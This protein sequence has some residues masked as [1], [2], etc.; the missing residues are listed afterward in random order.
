M[1]PSHEYL[2]TQQNRVSQAAGHEEYLAMRRMSRNEL[3]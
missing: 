3:D 2:Q 1:P